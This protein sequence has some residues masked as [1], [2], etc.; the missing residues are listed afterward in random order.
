V[1]IIGKNPEHICYGVP[2]VYSETAPHD[3][4][5]N[6]KWL[7]INPAA[8]TEGGYWLMFQDAITGEVS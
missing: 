6:A 4:G 2:G 7:P 3:L 1:G 5:D 8:P